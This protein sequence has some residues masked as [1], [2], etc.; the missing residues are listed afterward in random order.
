MGSSAS[1]F[2]GACFRP[3]GGNRALT[4]GKSGAFR[5]RNASGKKPPWQM[6]GYFNGAFL[7]ARGRGRREAPLR[8]ALILQKRNGGSLRGAEAQGVSPG[9]SGVPESYGSFTK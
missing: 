9:L 8:F 6:R 5:G 2:K 4:G 7:S 1:F 3:A